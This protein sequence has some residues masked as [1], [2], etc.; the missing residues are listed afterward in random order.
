MRCDGRGLLVSAAN[1]V[2][3]ISFGNSYFL[4]IYLQETT[5]KSNDLARAQAGTG[6]KLAASSLLRQIKGKGSAAGKGSG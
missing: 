5:V 1:S 3:G 4:Y 6:E 2:H